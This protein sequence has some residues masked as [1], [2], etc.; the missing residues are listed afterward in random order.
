M[1]FGEYLKQLRTEQRL[2][3]RQFCLKNGFDPGNYSRLERGHFP[4]PR[5]EKIAEYARA[6]NLTEGSTEWLELFDLAAAEQGQLPRDLM[7]D[8]ELVEKLPVVFRTMRAKHVSPE[9]LDD[10]AEKIRRG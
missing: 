5:D 7:E 8:E 6:L 10:L 1:K 3:L 9:L 4:P 2:S